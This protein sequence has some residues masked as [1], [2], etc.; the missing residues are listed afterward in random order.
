MDGGREGE[1]GGGRKERRRRFTFTAEGGFVGQR[2]GANVARLGIRVADGHK[3][4]PVILRLR[5]V[6]ILVLTTDNNN[7]HGNVNISKTKVPNG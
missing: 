4:V 3:L 6:F 7:K 2:L 5:L 1:G